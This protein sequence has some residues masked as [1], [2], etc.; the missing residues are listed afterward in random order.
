VLITPMPSVAGNIGA[1]RIVVGRAIAHPL[2][3]PE[4]EREQER[5]I[6]R[7]M[8]ARALEVLAERIA[9]QTVRQAS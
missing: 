9:S 2:G 7:Q 5:E 6:R 3:A 4:M 8:V 1:N